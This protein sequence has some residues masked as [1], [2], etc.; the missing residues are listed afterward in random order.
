MGFYY[1]IEDILSVMFEQDCFKVVYIFLL[2]RLFRLWQLML[3]D[4]CD[5]SDGLADLLE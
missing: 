4:T 3:L 2:P 5:R 1:M